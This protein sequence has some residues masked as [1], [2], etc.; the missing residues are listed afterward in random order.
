MVSKGGRGYNG[1]GPTSLP[2]W[3]ELSF[4]VSL[5]SPWP[6]GGLLSLLGILGFH[7]YFSR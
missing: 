1:V 3:W 7:F 5:G 4:Q 6:R 2:S